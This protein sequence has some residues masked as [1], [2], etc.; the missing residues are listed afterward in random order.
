MLFSILAPRAATLYNIQ[1]HSERNWLPAYALT[2]QIIVTFL[3]WV[4][5]ISRFSINGRAGFDDVLIFLA[6]ILGTAVT[7]AC[8]LCMCP[9]LALFCV[10]NYLTNYQLCTNMG[11]TS[12]YGVSQSRIGGKGD[13]YLDPLCQMESLLIASRSPISLRFCSFGVP[14]SPKYQS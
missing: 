13:W 11:S 5:I 14:A 4:R 2:I 10:Q 7:A 6:W 9:S 12:I 1:D 8:I 3:V